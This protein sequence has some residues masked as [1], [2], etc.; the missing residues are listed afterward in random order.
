MT[1]EE[2]VS[3]LSDLKA[4]N[5]A[6]EYAFYWNLKMS[7][8]K[9]LRSDLPRWAKCYGARDISSAFESMD[10][11]E[12]FAHLLTV[13]PLVPL[14]P[15]NFTDEE[16][17]SYGLSAEEISELRSEDEW[18]VQWIGVPQGLSSAAPFWNVHIAAG[19]N[20]LFSERWRKY[21]LLYVDDAM[22]FAGTKIR[23]S[24]M[25]R[26]FAAAC[27]VL[28][29][30]LSTK[31]DSEI[32]EKVHCAGLDFEKG[33]VVVDDSGGTSSKVGTRQ[34]RKER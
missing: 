26:L 10:L 7:T 33:G 21:W 28:G 4:L 11:E 9:E 16:L 20:K 2:A 22:P 18:L 27:T 17:Q 3:L 23:A 6:I 25:Q 24:H 29:K 34:Q 13:V 14:G 5:A 30:G 32:T 31:V 12:E 8:L 15:E 1:G 19:F